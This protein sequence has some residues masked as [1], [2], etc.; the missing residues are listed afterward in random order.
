MNT[1]AR[2]AL[3]GAALLLQACGG[4]QRD[5]TYS[6][7]SSSSSSSGSSSSSSGSPQEEQL[8]TV[9][10]Q[11]SQAAVSQAFFYGEDY[12]WLKN[13]G[14]SLKDPEQAKAYMSFA[15]DVEQS[16]LFKTVDIPGLGE[17]N[18]VDFLFK[19]LKKL[20]LS[21]RDDFF[22]SIAHGAGDI[23][24]RDRDKDPKVFVSV[25]AEDVLAI[26][27]KPDYSFDACQELEVKLQN[28]CSVHI[29]LNVEIGGRRSGSAGSTSQSVYLTNTQVKIRALKLW[30]EFISVE[31]IPGKNNF[32]VGNSTIK[33]K[34]K[35]LEVYD[36]HDFEGVI[37]GRKEFQ[38]L[39]MDGKNLEG[40]LVLIIKDLKSGMIM[41]RKIEYL[42]DVF[43][44]Q[45]L[46]NEEHAVIFDALENA[47]MS[48]GATIS[49]AAGVS[50]MGNLSL[51]PKMV[52]GKPISYD[53][54]QA[55]TGNHLFPVF[56]LASGLLDSIGGNVFYGIDPLSFNLGQG[57][58]TN[59]T[60]TN[61]MGITATGQH[62]ATIN[63][64]T[65]FK[66]ELVKA[67][68]V[69]RPLTNE[70]TAIPSLQSG[71]TQ[72]LKVNSS[73]G[74][75]FIKSYEI[76]DYKYHVNGQDYQMSAILD[77]VEAL[78]GEVK[79][80]VKSVH[81]KDIKSGVTVDANRNQGALFDGKGNK[82]GDLNLN[83]LMMG[84]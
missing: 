13:L 66:G 9:S 84:M 27:T 65:I 10:K 22:D 80:D 30:N 24:A 56:P 54:G 48:V 34:M 20:N 47:K 16:A 40:D 69:I 55:I 50:W 3:I 41:T 29:D 4:P 76:A 14:L 71:A 70:D 38:Y 73:E 75:D 36:P 58:T 43:K 64:N 82:A 52:G 46:A 33:I 62:S 42:V 17:I 63:G 49:N 7:S 6:S 83:W 23:F 60:D 59:E 19:V 68:T 28:Y 77:P 11:M 18:Q 2:I 45:I 67:N 61:Y 26:T 72:I 31:V 21:I 78:S 15:K 1:F 32:F 79:L 74:G 39:N 51:Q 44:M 35:D 53:F 81:I 37:F 12:D 8:K 5:N 57:L 25:D